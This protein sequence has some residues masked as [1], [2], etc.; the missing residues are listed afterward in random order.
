MWGD[1][2]Q[3]R[4]FV[5]ITDVVRAILKLVEC[6]ID[7]PVNIGTGRPTSFNELAAMVTRAAGYSP[8]IEH[9]PAAPSGVDYRVAEVDQLR[10]VYEPEVTLELGI[11]TALATRV[12]QLEQLGIITDTTKG[13]T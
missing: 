12:E 4:D 3:V 2:E 11:A 7:G 8:R 10:R 6:N 9:R 1:G 13:P 5:H